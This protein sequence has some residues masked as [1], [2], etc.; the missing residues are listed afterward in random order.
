[1]PETDEAEPSALGG[2]LDGC[3]DQYGETLYKCQTYMIP[4]M[5][6]GQWPG[7]AQ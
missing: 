5:P 7:V 3:G 1:M 6:E 4:N 2:L